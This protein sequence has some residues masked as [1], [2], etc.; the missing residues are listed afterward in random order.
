METVALILF[1]LL[2]G[3]LLGFIG[4]GGSGFMIAILTTGFGYS[5][6]TAMGTALAA[7]MFTSLSGTASQLRQKNTDIPA[8]LM[9]GLTG[10]LGSLAGSKVAF[11][12]APEQIKWFTAGMLVLSSLAMWL[13]VSLHKRAPQTESAV[14]EGFGLAARAVGLG[15]VTG[16]LTGAFGIGSTPFIQI[17]F[18]LFMGHD[19]RKA[20]GTSMLVILPVAAAGWLGYYGEGG[21]DAALL[22]KVLLGTMTGSYIGARFTKYAPAR[23]LQTGMIVTPIAAAI[24]LVL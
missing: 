5:V 11:L 8:G 18:L 21:F 20:A 23:L 16:F 17:G 15:L 24:L 6:H 12:I 4:A 19:M 7:M 1:M 14:P 13:R 10:I 9:A 2:L 22:V 3:L